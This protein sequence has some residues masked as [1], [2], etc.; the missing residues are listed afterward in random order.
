MRKVLVIDGL[1]IAK[2]V[3]AVSKGADASAW[4]AS[5]GMGVA[6]LQSAIG[7]EAQHSLKNAQLAS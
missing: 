5:V 2:A 1:R 6:D 3:V 7:P 4:L